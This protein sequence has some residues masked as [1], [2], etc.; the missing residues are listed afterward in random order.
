VEHLRRIAKTADVSDPEALKK[1]KF[2]LDGLAA[3]YKGGGGGGGG[4]GGASDDS[5]SLGVPTMDGAIN[6]ARG[7]GRSVQMRHERVA[8]IA[9][10]SDARAAAA[11]AV[12]RSGVAV[13]NN[14]VQRNTVAVRSYLRDKG[15]GDSGDS[16]AAH[17]YRYGSFPCDWNVCAHRHWHSHLGTTQF[18]THVSSRPLGH[19]HSTPSPDL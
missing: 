13:R 2:H 12:A 14:P 7:S 16:Y 8:S 10:A 15:D 1:H 9:A 5:S 6:R 19:T 18:T 11:S 17:R 3:R 4:G